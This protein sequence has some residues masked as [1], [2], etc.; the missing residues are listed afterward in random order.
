MEKQERTPQE[1]AQARQKASQAYVENRRNDGEKDSSAG[2]LAL[3]VLQVIQQGETA[4]IEQVIEQLLERNDWQEN[5][6]YLHTLQAILAGERD[7]ALAEACEMHYELV[8][9]LKIL[10]E[11]LQ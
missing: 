10:L 7:P 11:Q 3:A 5:K 6:T 9:E 1:A 4:E 8:A 2:R